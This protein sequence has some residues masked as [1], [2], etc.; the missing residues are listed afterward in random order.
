MDVTLVSVEHKEKSGHSILTFH[1][2]NGP[3]TK[4]ELLSLR[5][6]TVFGCL[7]LKLTPIVENAVLAAI[8]PQSREEMIESQSFSVMAFKLMKKK[9]TEERWRLTAITSLLSEQR[10][11]EACT[12]QMTGSLPFM[13]SLLGG[14]KATHLR[15]QE[16]DSGNT[17]TIDQQSECSEDDWDA[18]E[19]VDLASTF[20]LPRLNA[21]QEKAA[22]AFLTSKEDSI[23]IC[24][25]PPGTGKTTLLTSV[26]CQV[27]HGVSKIRT[28]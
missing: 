22:S 7:N 15:F 3:F 25:G 12:N 5:H 6:G 27:Y 14:K 20:R 11:Y 26:I 1:K 10:K 17:Y 28:Y 24:Q 2:N 8:L 4:D 18:P 19:I 9:T 16:D 23:T 13:Y 21:M